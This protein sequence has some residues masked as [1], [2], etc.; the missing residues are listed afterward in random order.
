[1]S[2]RS[3]TVLAADAHEADVDVSLAQQRADA[4]DHAGLVHVLDQQQVALAR[5]DVD[6]EVVDLDDVG[7]SCATVTETLVLPALVTRLTRI[8]SL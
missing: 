6:P 8:R 5:R 1:M 7:P 2:A 3:A 4:A